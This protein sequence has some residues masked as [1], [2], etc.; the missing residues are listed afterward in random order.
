MA[1]RDASLADVRDVSRV[2]G[3]QQG[4]P[5][6]WSIGFGFARVLSFGCP[7]GSAHFDGWFPGFPF[8]ALGVDAG[9]RGAGRLDV[10]AA[11]VLD[12]P[13]PVP[14]D[15]TETLGAVPGRL[16][17][18]LEDVRGFRCGWRLG[19][20]LRT[21]V[22]LSFS[23]GRFLAGPGHRVLSICLGAGHRRFSIR[24]SFVRR[25]RRGS[26][27]RLGVVFGL[28]FRQRFRLRLGRHLRAGLRSAS[29]PPSGTRGLPKIGR[30]QSV[31]AYGSSAPAPVSR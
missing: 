26:S 8:G 12:G 28:R 22:S 21:S 27:V 23:T 16:A 11:G 3:M 30:P 5:S 10:G 7:L 31:G 6:S 9:L 2:G 29:V 20:L 25:A 4:A 15:R 19:L 17:G 24:F 14:G 1:A 13:V 18:L